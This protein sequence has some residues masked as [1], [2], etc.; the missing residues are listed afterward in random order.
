MENKGSQSQFVEF[1]KVYRATL[2]TYTIHDY[3]NGTPGP[4]RVLR[5]EEGTTIRELTSERRG[6]VI[7]CVFTVAKQELESHD[8]VFF[9]YVPAPGGPSESIFFARLKRFLKP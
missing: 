6:D 3:R 1:P 5:S 8:L 7:T 2:G 9:F 4:G